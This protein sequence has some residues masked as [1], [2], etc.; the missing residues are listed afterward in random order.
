[1]KFSDQ[2]PIHLLKIIQ[3]LAGPDCFIEFGKYIYEKGKFSNKRSIF[4]VGISEA[5]VWFNDQCASLKNQEEIALQ[6]RIV[7]SDRKLFHLPMIDFLNGITRKNL[8]EIKHILQHF[9]IGDFE[10]FESGRSYHLYG[11]NLI[12][13]NEYVAFMGALLLINAPNASGPIDTR[14]VG[15]QLIN[16]YSALRWTNNSKMYKKL[17]S[18]I[19]LDD[20]KD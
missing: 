16:G 20:I 18:R 12:P 5:E 8:T 1:M 4:L 13:E 3:M 15:H 2:H 6:S 9:D 17:P 7:T 11:L 19:S 10:I 14:W